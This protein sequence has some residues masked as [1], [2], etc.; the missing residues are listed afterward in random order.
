MQHELSLQEIKKEW[1]GSLKAYIIG[2]AA[3]LLL[4]GVS[5][6][7]VIFKVLSDRHLIYSIVGLAVTQA[8]LQLLFFLH[9][10]Q[11]GKP[12][13]ETFVFAFMVLVLLIVAGGSLW[14]MSD[15]DSR[16]MHDMTME[17]KHD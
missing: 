6:L 10:G 5:F 15:L 2:F 4:T 9:L 16:M 13:W 3:S 8:I 1:H 17:K 7:L 14:I 12:K 11:E